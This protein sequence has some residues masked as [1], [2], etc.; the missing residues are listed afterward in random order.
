MLLGWA[1]AL[2]VAAV[3]VQAASI[4]ITNAGFEADAQPPATL[5]VATPPGWSIYNPANINGVSDVVGTLNPATSGHF[6]SAPEGSN[7]ALVFMGGPAVGE[8]GLQQTLAATLQANTR[9]TLTVEVGNIDEGTANLGYF[10][11]LGFPGY[12]IDLLAG[13]TVIASDN[14]SLAG[15][16][17]EGQFLASTLEVSIG[18]THGQL[19]QALGIRLVNLNIPGTIPEP[20]IEVNFDD[21][22]LSSEAIHVVDGESGDWLGTASGT[23]HGTTVSAGEWIYTGVA[24]DQR[25]D[26]P[27]DASESN[28]DLTEVRLTRDGTYLYIL[29]RFRDISAFN[30]P[31]I[32]FGIDLDRS[33]GDSTPLGFLGDES[34]LI[35]TGGPG[36]DPEFMVAIHNTPHPTEITQVEIYDDNAGNGT[37]W[38]APSTGWQAFLSPTNNLIEARIPLADLGLTVSNDFRFSLASFDNGSTGDPAAP[39]WN[40][41]TDTTVDYPTCDAMDVMTD[42]PGSTDNAWDRDLNDGG[43]SHGFIVDLAVL[44]VE[45]SAFGLD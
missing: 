4:P 12:R 13:S 28:Y 14:N 3:S 15:S 7:V 44:P 9:Y 26:P 41:L 10:N 34:G 24:N 42:T 32:C 8:A 35:Y 11:L 16:L 38:Y 37:D 29:A 22:R 17:G 6:A 33:A 39:G 18:A 30:E 43:V 45:L 2:L 20:G 19:G 36:F 31:H 40:N 5:T 27:D 23:G 25:G 1:L 21:V